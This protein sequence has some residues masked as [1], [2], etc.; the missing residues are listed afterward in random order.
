LFSTLFPSRARPNHGLF[1]ETRLRELLASGEVESTVVAPV[2]W[3]PF[4][5]GR[6]GRCAAFAATPEREERNGIDVWHPRYALPP[7]VGMSVAPLTLAA[8]ARSTIARL[9]EAGRDFDLID[10]HYYYP[11]GAAAALLARWFRKPFV[12]TGRG[13]DLNLLPDYAVPRKWIGWTARRAAASILVSR[14]LQE[15]L[16][17]LGAE[18][19]RTHV[20]R[21]G[22]DLDRFRP[23][24]RLECRRRL[25]LEEGRWLLSVGHLVALKGHD[26]AIAA[27]PGLPPDVRLAIVGDGEERRRLAAVA[28]RL[29]VTE[30]VRLVGAVPQDELVCWYNAAVALVLCSSREGSPNVV[31]ES[32][33]CGTPVAAT[34]VGGVP[35]LLEDPAAG[36]LIAERTPSA[37][38]AAVLE[39]F[40]AGI[41]PSAVRAYASRF[42]WE[43][44]TRGQI[45]LFRAVLRGPGL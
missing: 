14:P 1:V 23:L 15:R 39:I 37:L 8:G 11:D 43:E 7:K 16:V 36:R 24:D 44:T 26:I 3:F 40:A 31:L 18:R 9:I 12:V 19:E 30:R 45:D 28:A 21:N 33:A 22:V 25:G 38:A 32:L 34:A 13:T 17:Q 42:G 2:P 20:L 35:E 5:H 27:L 10:A 41:R 4:R 29:D 6:F